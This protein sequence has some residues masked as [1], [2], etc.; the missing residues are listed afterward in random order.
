MGKTLG[1]WA[2]HAK[3]QRSCAILIGIRVAGSAQ[4]LACRQNMALTR[5]YDSYPQVIHRVIHMPPIYKFHHPN[6]NQRLLGLIIVILYR[7]SSQ[8]SIDTA[9]LSMF[10]KPN[11]QRVLIRM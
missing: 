3:S 8:F 4:Q 5:G 6:P 2:G 9:A 1:F 10:P 11:S 7:E